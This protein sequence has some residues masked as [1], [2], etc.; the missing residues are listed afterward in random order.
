MH[1]RRLFAGFFAVALLA[2]GSVAEADSVPKL[3]NYQGKLVQ[4]NGT[5]PLPNGEYS[6][7]FELFNAPAEGILVW[8]E[9]RQ[10]TV[11][12]G[13]F[14]VILGG[15]GAEAVA[16]AAV[17]DL[18]FAFGDAE[19]YLETTIV[20]GPGG[21][22][23]QTLSP[24]QQLASVPFAVQAQDA[25]QAVNADRLGGEA[26]SF[27][28]P[29]GGIMAYGGNDDPPGW[30]IC[31]GRAVS[32]SEYPDLFIAIGETFEAGDGS[33]NFNLPNGQGLVL[34][35]TGSQEINEREK[36]GPELGKT[37]EDQ[38][39]RIR[40]SFRSRKYHSSA[41]VF[42]FGSS[43]LFSEANQSSGN[44]GCPGGTGALGETIITFDSLGSSGS[45][46]SNTTNGETRVSSL[47]VNYIIKY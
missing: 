13:I 29:P 41:G 40:G 37:E 22:L 4:A 33:T 1:T 30:L 12:G 24:R 3:I 39:Q 36:V 18:A 26:P 45:R 44:A 47:G 15:A 38:M 35:G 10:V 14:N 2:G 27:W 19:R 7:R 6:L 11:V 23:N 46:V 17:N 16:G 32:R 21:P 25:S 42:I 31:D 8:G 28:L 34:R 9:T 20:S 43:G 5:D